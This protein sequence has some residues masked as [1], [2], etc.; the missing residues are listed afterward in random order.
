ML[1][2]AKYL[3]H[4]AQNRSEAPF[5]IIPAKTGIQEPMIRRLIETFLLSQE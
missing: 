2:K 3:S 4:E 5:Y 1:A